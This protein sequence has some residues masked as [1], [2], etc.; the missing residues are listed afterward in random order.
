MD[1]TTT[2][3]KKR[4]GRLAFASLLALGLGLAALAALGSVFACS[5]AEGD[6][7]PAV[8][9][10]GADAAAVVPCSDGAAE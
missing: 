1:R 4:H 6:P 7:A 5:G 9:E 3:S 10:G 8:P 2:T